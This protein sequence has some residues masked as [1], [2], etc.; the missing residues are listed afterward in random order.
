MPD[1]D[2]LNDSMALERDCRTQPLL[3]IMLARMARC[4]GELASTSISSI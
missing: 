3:F 1:E 4:T 2:V